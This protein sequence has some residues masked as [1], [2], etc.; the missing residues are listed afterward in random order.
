MF[1]R[2][3]LATHHFVSEG[4]KCKLQSTLS[5]KQPVAKWPSAFSVY[6]EIDH[7]ISELSVF[8]DVDNDALHFGYRLIEW[9]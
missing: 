1:L 2:V 3:N 5:A 4:H 6:W 7:N 9:R 8:A